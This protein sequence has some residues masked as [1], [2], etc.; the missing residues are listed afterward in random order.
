M[1]RIF[2][3][4]L[5]LCLSP[6]GHAE[7]SRASDWI[8]RIVITSDGQLLGQVQDLALDTQTNAVEYVVIS[9]G[10]YLVNENLIAVE[11]ALIQ[12]G[13]DGVLSIDTD[14]LADVPRFND[15]AWP[16]EAQVTRPIV[17]A[18]SDGGAAA[19]PKNAPTAEIVGASKRLKFADGERTEETVR[20][21]VARNE[22]PSIQPKNVSSGISGLTPESRL[23]T[24][25]DTDKDGYLSRQEIGPYFQPDMKFGDYDLDANGGL[26]SFEFD[27]LQQR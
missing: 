27:V 18:E 25:F 6:V 5:C 24:Q 10:S 26:D 3:V 21:P 14:A 19:P 13:E 8:D 1:Y 17:K 11:P 16:N 2:V 9:V 20:A 12:Q 7:V 15:S 4:F 23:F 22:L